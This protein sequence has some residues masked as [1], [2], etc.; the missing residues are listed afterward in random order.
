[1]T[2][3]CLTAR[4]SS[5][6]GL[7]RTVSGFRARSALVAPGSIRIQPHI[8]TAIASSSGEGRLGMHLS[9]IC[10]LTHR[11]IKADCHL[12]KNS[13]PPEISSAPECPWMSL[14]YWRSTLVHKHQLERSG[15]ITPP[16]PKSFHTSDSTNNFRRSTRPPWLR[17]CPLEQLG[18]HVPPPRRP[19]VPS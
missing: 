8:E 11:A 1:M 7:G 16:R 17:I 2:R 3:S 19:L 10:R 13:P 4:R 9:S 12:A 5:A 14:F 6:E 15:S 18:P